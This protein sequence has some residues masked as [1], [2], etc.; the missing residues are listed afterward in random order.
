L[1]FLGYREGSSIYLRFLDS[2]SA[3]PFHTLSWL[4]FVKG[5]LGNSR[6]AFL[7]WHDEGYPS[8]VLPLVERRFWGARFA[9]SV[10]FDAPGGP[11][12][13]PPPE[14][15]HRAFDGYW[16]VRVCDPERTLITPWETLLVPVHVIDLAR[17]NPSRSQ[18]RAARQAERRGLVVEELSGFSEELHEL[19][20]RVKAQRGGLTFGRR[21]LQNL[22]S[23]MAG[24]TFGFVGRHEGKPVAFILNFAHN[25]K[26]VSYLHGFD[27]AFAALRPMSAL[28]IR[29]VESAIERGCSEFSLGSTAPGDP[30]L[31]AFKES[32]GASA[33]PMRIHIKQGA[34][35]RVAERAR[36]PF[37][38]SL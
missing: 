35:F 17:F 10:P 27:R 28:I 21:A 9:F 26:A 4:R 37:R 25:Q 24:H 7:V 13:S 23:E 1:E 18:V 6:I 32:F 5:V 15:W 14:R 12:G 3:T 20:M 29:S 31:A 22:F 33:R 34:L 8:G 30:G 11:L 2:P 16:H 36:R 38:K 19:Y